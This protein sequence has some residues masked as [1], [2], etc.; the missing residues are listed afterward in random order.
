[1]ATVDVV[2]FELGGERT[3]EC[4]DFIARDLK[5]VEFPFHPHQKQSTFGIDVVIGVNNTVVWTN[6]DST[7]H[8]VTSTTKLFDS[9]NMNAGDT[10]TFTF[11]TPGTYSYV[12]SYHPW[13]KGT[14][15]VKGP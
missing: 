14:V 11:T 6:K 2:E 7:P 9:G 3:K 1:M 13:M 12:C 5:S 4:F 15:I 10:F 8:T